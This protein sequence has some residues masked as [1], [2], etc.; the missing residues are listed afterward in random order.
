M[1][2][3]WRDEDKGELVVDRYTATGET[4]FV[5]RSGIWREG[6]GEKRERVEEG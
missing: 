4:H 5:H 6:D 3:G 1:N 2:G